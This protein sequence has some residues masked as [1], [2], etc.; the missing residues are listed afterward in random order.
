MISE[1]NEALR[2]LM[3]REMPMRRGD[4]DIQFDLPK[5]DWSARLSKPTLNIYLYDILENIELRG[6][7][8]WTQKDNGDGTVTLE[9][10]PVRVNFYY[11][12]TSWAKEIQDEQQLLSSA[13]ITL[14]RQ[15]TIP[16]DLLPKGLQGQRL[17]VR[18]ETVQNKGLAKMSD[19]W[20]PVDNDPHPG[21]RLMVTLT[22][23]PHQP[24]V[25]PQV[26][27]SEMRF[28]QTPPPT[29]RAGERPKEAAQSKT[30]FAIS[31]KIKSQK[32]SPSTL[33]LV[34]AES[35]REI[36]VDEN[37]DFRILRLSEGAYHLDIVFN[38][39]VLRREKIN[40]PADKVEITV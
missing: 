9:R 39:R 5:R 2:E 4:I 10:N 34:L 36:S 30:Y 21:I 35:G 32:H 33:K 26:A 25:T 8:Q 6:S 14:L 31:G 11:L 20:G 24:V 7:E 23:D 15:P 28:R 27:T 19:F 3:L 18:L 12:V 40:V 37:G 29:S 1:L 13:M 22:V 38:E 17:P 16:E